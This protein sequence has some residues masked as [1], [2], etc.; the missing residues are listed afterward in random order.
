[1]MLFFLGFPSRYLCHHMPPAPHPTA[2]S[3][4]SWKAVCPVAVTPKI[5]PVKEASRVFSG[6]ASTLSVFKDLNNGSG[7]LS[8][9]NPK[10]ILEVHRVQCA[11]GQFTLPFPS[12]I[13]GS[14]CFTNLSCLRGQPQETIIAGYQLFERTIPTGYK[15]LFK[16]IRNNS[17]ITHCLF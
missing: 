5:Q 14:T 8:S 6:S 11:A 16:K 7:S 9:R 17:I 1:M 13:T 15:F 2:G 10:R 12:Q 3:P 4:C